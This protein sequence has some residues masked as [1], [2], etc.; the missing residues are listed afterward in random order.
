MK[1]FFKKIIIEVLIL[2][3]KVVLWRFK[4]KIIAVTGSVGKTS[5][6]DAIYTA[7]KDTLH[8]RKN[9]KTFNTE[10]GVPLTILG[11]PNGWSSFG[12]WTLNI[13]RGFVVPFK[14]KYPEWLVLEVGVDRPGDMERTAKWLR[15]N[16]VVLTAFP[17][18]PVHVEYFDSPEAIISE[19][20]KLVDFL[21]SDGALILNAD[22]QQVLELKW[23]TKSKVKKILTYGSMDS[24]DVFIS[25]ETIIYEDFDGVKTPTGISLKVNYQGNS[26]PVALHGVLGIQHMYP[27]VSALAT[28][29]SLGIPFL[30]MTSSFARHA[31]PK[32]RMRIIDGEN[33][34]TIIDDSYN[35]S[36]IAVERALEVLDQLESLG[37]KI[38]VLGDMTEIGNYTVREHKKVGKLVAD[39]GISH[40]FAV[41]LRSRDIADEAIKNGMPEG[42][43]YWLKTSEE[44]VPELKKLLNPGN[45]VLVKGSQFMRMEKI[46]EK[47]MAQPDKAGELLVRQEGEW[48]RR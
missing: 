15:P 18:V 35:S 36:P 45:A 48:K 23:S 9:Q 46:V 27:V 5:T 42:N 43:V 32:S 8:I 17:T 1:E 41:G 26:I 21:R 2:E 39:K 33:R 12:L 31:S 20:K 47:I 4:P 6:K 10:I 19:K 11:L 40:L 28:G 3:A 44:V 14:L 38:A 13:L 37:Q 30:Q 29:L 24:A 16:V 25:N 34:T 7:L 22:D